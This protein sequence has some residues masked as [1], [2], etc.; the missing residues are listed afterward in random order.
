M[1]NNAINTVSFDNLIDIDLS[2]W[3]VHISDNAF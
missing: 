3:V 2:H 1:I